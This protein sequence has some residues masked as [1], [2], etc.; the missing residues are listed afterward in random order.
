[1]N[2]K[3]SLHSLEQVHACDYMLEIPSNAGKTTINSRNPISEYVYTCLVHQTSTQ[4]PE[5]SFH[6]ED[7]RTA[8][9]IS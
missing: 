7:L 1:M 8:I 5:R 9:V 3:M 6:V 2:C 4:Q